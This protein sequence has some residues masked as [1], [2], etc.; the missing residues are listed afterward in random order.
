[1][2]R[3][4]AQPRTRHLGYT[5]G[6]L[7]AP[8]VVFEPTAAPVA[9]VV[10]SPHS[11]MEWPPD[12]RPVA[13]PEA[14]LSTWDAFVDDLW[15]GARGAGATLIAA[16]F[17]RAYIDVNR[18]ADDIDAE[19]VEGHWPTPL[20][21]TDYTR[22]GMGLI[23]R[24]ALPEVPMYNRRLTPEEIQARLEHYYRPYRAALAQVIDRVQAAFGT[25]V[26]VNAHSMKSRGNA[27]NVDSGTPRPD[28]VV[29][30]RHGVTADPR[31]TEWAAAWFREHGFAAQVNTPYQGGDLVAAFGAPGAGRHSIQIELNRALYM[32]EARFIRSA[33]FEAI[34]RT[35][36]AF[37]GALAAHIEAREVPGQR[38]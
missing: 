35:L 38:A 9:I 36:T 17:P 5:P 21:A 33:G 14:I 15:T 7:G 24:L 32:D 12:F 2:G 30:D 28:V 3:R 23:R 4:A 27:M 29:S 25:V 31:I 26:H 34:H 6:V 19:L 20:A 18:A 8:V 13:P 37:V 22:R 1:M 10:D 16:R 11:G